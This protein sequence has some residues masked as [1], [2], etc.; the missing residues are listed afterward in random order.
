VPL[1]PSPFD[2]FAALTSAWHSAMVPMSASAVHGLLAS[3]VKHC[4][5][6]PT[7]TA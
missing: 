7:V 4:S 5:N 2:A 3:A 6:D 1:A